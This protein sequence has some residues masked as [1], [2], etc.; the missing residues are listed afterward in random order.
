MDRAG[1]SSLWNVSHQH[2]EESKAKLFIKALLACHFVQ[3]CAGNCD[4]HI[5]I[6]DAMQ[7]FQFEFSSSL[8]PFASF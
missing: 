4:R 2:Y 1:I 3:Q 5:H 8:H 6:P 7:L